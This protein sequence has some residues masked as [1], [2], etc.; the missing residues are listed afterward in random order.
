MS[1]PPYNVRIIVPV[2]TSDYNAE[3]QQAVAPVTPPDFTFDVRNI[4]SGSPFIEGRYDL[5]TNAPYVIQLAQ[6]TEAEGFDGIFVTDFDMCGVE[7]AREV[8]NIPIIGGFVPC[9]FAAMSIAD[10]FS[11]VTILDSVVA[12]QTEHVTQYGLTDAFA[13]IRSI[14]VPVPELTN[15]EVVRQAVF[16]TATQCITEDGAQAIVLGCTGFIDIAGPV[17]QALA[18]AGTPAPVIDP[19]MTSFTFLQMLVRTGQ[20]QSRLTYY[21]PNPS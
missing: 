12:M 5:Y 7:P 9:A 2:N 10:R 11:I 15:R 6:E 21:P 1:G 8:V 19:N 14:N 16:Q 18:A 4:T 17:Q 3:V 13:S 20:M